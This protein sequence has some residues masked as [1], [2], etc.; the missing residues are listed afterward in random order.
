MDLVIALLSL[1]ATSSL[2]VPQPASPAFHLPLP[3]LCTQLSWDTSFHSQNRPYLIPLRCLLGS[4]FFLLMFGIISTGPAYQIPSYLLRIN[5]KR[6]LEQEEILCPLFFLPAWSK[7]LIYQWRWL[8][9]S[10]LQST[11][12]CQTPQHIFTG[13]HMNCLPLFLQCKLQQSRIFV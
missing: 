9:L 5:S 10:F 8:P 7:H 6:I 12:L 2:G 11:H 4:C 1:E 3:H 13:L